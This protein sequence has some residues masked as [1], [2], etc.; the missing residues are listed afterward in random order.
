MSRIE[1][2]IRNLLLNAVKYTPSGGNICIS[3]SV[4]SDKR[5]VTMRSTPSPVTRQNKSICE[6]TALGWLRFEVSDDGS[7]KSSISKRCIFM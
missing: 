5:T 4:R 1:Q 7:G 6:F 3:I 2:V